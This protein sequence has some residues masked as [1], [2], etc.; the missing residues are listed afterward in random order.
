VR[1]ERTIWLGF[2]GAL[3]LGEEGIIKVDASW[4]LIIAECLTTFISLLIT[5]NLR[6]ETQNKGNKLTS[7][8]LKSIKYLI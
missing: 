2:A 6:G 3:D 4:Q 7:Q 8:S 1:L 5:F